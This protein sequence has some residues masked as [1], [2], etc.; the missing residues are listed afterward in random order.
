M[1]YAFGDDYGQSGL[2]AGG[3]AGGTEGNDDATNNSDYLR[4]IGKAG[5]GD[6]GRIEYDG[7]DGYNEHNGTDAEANT[8]SGEGGGNSSDSTVTS[9][10]RGA[11]GIVIVRFGP[12]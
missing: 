8:G 9:G 11:S 12:L 3:G 4:P 7:G 10:G 2:F 6:G 5:G 1:S